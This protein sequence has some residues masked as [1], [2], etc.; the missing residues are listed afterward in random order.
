[1]TGP[2]L[3]IV[4]P[5]YREEKR[6][7]SS[8]EKIARYLAGE[9]DLRGTELI[10]VDDG[11]ED[12]TAEAGAAG[13]GIGLR[14]RVIRL[15]KNRGKGCA[16]RAGALAASGKLILVTDADLSTPIEEW[17]KLAATGAPIAI[18]SRAVDESTVKVRQPFYRQ[19]LGRLFNRLVQLLAVPGIRD[20]Q[21]GFKLFSY[22]AARAAL[23]L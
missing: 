1:M 18:G 21:C 4:I 15:P 16:V 5:A 8:L 14:V 17:R 10:V 23:A 9:P 22:D 7:F 2:A 12:S 19:A 6:L 3:S 13:A 11:S 20:T